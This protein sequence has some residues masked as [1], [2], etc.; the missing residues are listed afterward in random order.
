M[1]AATG[2]RELVERGLEC[3]ADRELRPQRT[4][5]PATGA[6]RRRPAAGLGDLRLIRRGHGRSD[7]RH[8]S[9]SFSAPAKRSM[10]AL[11][12]T[13]VAHTSSASRSAASSGY[14]SAS[15]RPARMSRSSSAAWTS[16]ASGTRDRELV[17]VRAVVDARRADGGQSASSSSLGSR[18][19]ERGDVAQPVRAERREVDRRGERA[20]RL[21]G[22]DVARRLVAPDVLLARAQRHH[23]GAPAVDVGRPPDQPAGHLADEARTSPRAGPGT[24]RRTSGCSPRPPRCTRRIPGRL[25]GRTKDLD[26]KRAFVMTLRAREQDIRR[27]RAASNIC[28]NQALCALAATVYLATIGPHG[29]R[30]VA[31][32]GAAQAR[33]LELALAEAGAP[34]IHDG[35]YLNEFAVRV[36]DAER[37][38]AALLER[39]VLGGP[40]AGSLV[41]GRSAVPGGRPAGVRT[42]VTTDADIERFAGALRAELRAPAEAAA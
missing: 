14:Q 20:Q 11:V 31:A 16:A 10:S 13:S 28:T 8:A 36:P 5:S 19:A 42:E 33:R 30:D 18:R 38:H 17:Q 22:A 25:V 7:G 34:R 26:G 37:V 24:A 3:R 12:V 35:P 23:V 39:G 21:V 15:G 32:L 29:L 27:D 40:A 1:L 41:S 6:A 4:P 9:T 2:P